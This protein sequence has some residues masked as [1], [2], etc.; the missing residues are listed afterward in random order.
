MSKELDEDEVNYFVEVTEEIKGSGD[1]TDRVNKAE[2]FLSAVS[3]LDRKGLTNDIFVSS[4]EYPKSNSTRYRR[5][6]PLRNPFKLADSVSGEH[7]LAEL[8]DAFFTIIKTYHVEN[9]TRYFHK[10]RSGEDFYAIVNPHIKRKL[11]RLF[12]RIGVKYEMAMKIMKELKIDTDGDTEDS[13]N[14]A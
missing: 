11:Y 12:S 3:Y 9:G 6:E 2:K 1:S 8:T 13:Y 14:N 4:E 7:V 5:T 10:T